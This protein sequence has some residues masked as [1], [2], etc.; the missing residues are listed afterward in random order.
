MWID[1]PKHTPLAR[2]SRLSE[3]RPKETGIDLFRTPERKDDS[4]WR[5]PCA[6]LNIDADE[7]TAV[8]KSQRPPYTV[9]MRHIRK[10]LAYLI[11]IW[12]CGRFAEQLYAA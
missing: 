12:L 1:W 5:G 9:P 8:V 3:L 4:G 11:M 2:Y 6:L 10:H 7:G